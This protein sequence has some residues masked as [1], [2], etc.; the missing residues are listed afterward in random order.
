MFSVHVQALPH[1]CADAARFR[2]S[3]AALLDGCTAH[4]LTTPSIYL[5]YC[6]KL[7]VRSHRN[8]P[9]KMHTCNSCVQTSVMHG[10]DVIPTICPATADALREEMTRRWAAG[11]VERRIGWQVALV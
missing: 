4:V 9:R 1:S 11:R 8:G 5:T 7:G 10:C 6:A 3:L 2:A